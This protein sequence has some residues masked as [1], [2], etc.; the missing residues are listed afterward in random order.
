SNHNKKASQMYSAVIATAAT[1]SAASPMS[2]HR[3]SRSESVRLGIQLPAVCQARNNIPMATTAITGAAASAS[4]RNIPTTVST[5]AMTYL[6]MAMARRVAPFLAPEYFSGV[7]TMLIGLL[8]RP[9]WKFSRTPD[10]VTDQP[11]Q[12]WHDHAAHHNG[13]DQHPDAHDHP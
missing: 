8:C 12:R 2:H 1:H 5:T 9:D 4:P 7:L 3:S 13:I 6:P 11:K 10:L